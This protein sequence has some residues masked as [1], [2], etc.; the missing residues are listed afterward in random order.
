LMIYYSFKFIEASRSSIV[1]SLKG[2]VVLAGS[3][4]YFGT[5]PLKHQIIGGGLTV[6]GVLIM[7]LAQAKILRFTKKG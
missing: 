4:I 5:L 3:W 7:T 2:I 6:I 1:Q